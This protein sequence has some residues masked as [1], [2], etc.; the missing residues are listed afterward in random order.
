MAHSHDCKCCAHKPQHG[1]PRSKLTWEEKLELALR[2]Q[3]VAFLD[4][5]E[6]GCAND[7]IKK[8]KQFGDAGEQMVM[9]LRDSRLAGVS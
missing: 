4:T 6:C 7:C 5:K 2:P 1:G 9:N 3:V 8:V